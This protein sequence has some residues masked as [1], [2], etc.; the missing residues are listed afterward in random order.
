MPPARGTRVRSTRQADAIVAV[1]SGMPAF[2]GARDVHDALR[3]SGEHVGLATVYRHLHVLAERGEVDTIHSGSGES[4]YRLRAS[5]ATCHLV[6]RACG[7]VVDVDG[8]EVLGWGRQV[9]DE[10]GFTFSGYS[11]ELSGLCPA[12][13]E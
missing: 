5:S 8:S 1:L 4:R 7:R 10:A 2:C 13:A 12:H 3:R 9:A 6:C 11:V